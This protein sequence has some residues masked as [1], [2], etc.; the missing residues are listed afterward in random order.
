MMEPSNYT[1]SCG[2]QTKTGWKSYSY[3]PNKLHTETESAGEIA[4]KIHKASLEENPYESIV[5][6]AVKINPMGDIT[7]IYLDIMSNGMPQLGNNS[8]FNSK[9]PA[10][11]HRC[12]QM[13][14]K[15]PYPYGGELRVRK[16]HND[17]KDNLPPL[18]GNGCC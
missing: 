18:K 3:D 13:V 11:Y 1:Y 4:S 16:P 15:I 5:L 17:E 12:Y 9:Y 7:Q 8:I 2:F 6:T 14:N 10:N